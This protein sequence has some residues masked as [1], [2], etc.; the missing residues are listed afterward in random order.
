MS[1]DGELRNRWENTHRWSPGSGFLARRLHINGEL[2][3]RGLGELGA[4]NRRLVHDGGPRV[5]SKR[6]PRLRIA[7]PVRRPSYI[8]DIDGREKH[9]PP[10]VN[11]DLWCRLMLDGYD[12]TGVVSFESFEEESESDVVEAT[13]DVEAAPQK[14]SV[15][16]LVSMLRALRDAGWDARLML[17]TVREGDAYVMK[18]RIEATN[19]VVDET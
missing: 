3:T 6:L 11:P 2:D 4:D 9:P 12:K 13:V 8:Y 5:P 17:E 15:L 19:E 14:P 18:A 7:Y 10:G 1:R 16:E